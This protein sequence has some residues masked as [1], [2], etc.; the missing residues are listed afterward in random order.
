MTKVSFLYLDTIKGP[1]KD[2]GSLLCAI[3]IK[4][5]H[6]INAYG[7]DFKPLV[8]QYWLKRGQDLNKLEHQGTVV[9]YLPSSEVQNLKTEE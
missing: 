2:L 3:N 9:Y 8:E 6:L 7:E 1:L 4:G 5:Y